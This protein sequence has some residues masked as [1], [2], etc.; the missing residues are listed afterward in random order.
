MKLT[1]E[2]LKE[3]IEKSLE[4]NK[5]YPRWRVGQSFFNT[6]WDMHPDIA[7]EI[8]STEYDPFYDTGRM[9]S[10]IEFITEEQKNEI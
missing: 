5:K 9:T 6:L 4:N 7:N 3:V 1:K 10:C 2:Q 8:N